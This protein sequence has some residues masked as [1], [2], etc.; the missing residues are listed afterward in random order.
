[1][2]SRSNV[3]LVMNQRDLTG[4]QYNACTF[5]AKGQNII[6]GDIKDVTVSEVNFPY[7]IPNVQAGYD[8][9]TLTNV[10]SGVFTDLLIVV[11]AGFYTG[12]ELATAVNAAIALT[13]SQLKTPVDISNQPVV[14]YDDTSNR[15]IF[16][17]P[18]APLTP[19]WG[20]WNILSPYT[21]PYLQPSQVNDLGKDLLSIMGFQRLSNNVMNSQAN[22]PV[23]ASSGSAPLAFTQ[24]IDI[25]SPQLCKFQYFRDG[26]TTNL[27]RRSDV[28]CRLYICNNIS[29]LQGAPE[30]C[31]PFV[32][33]R[34]FFNARVM[35]WTADNSVGTIDIN[36]YDDVGQPLKTTWQ[37][38]PYQIT[39][40]AMENPKDEGSEIRDVVGMQ[41]Y[42][43]Y[44]NENAAAWANISVAGKN[45]GAPRR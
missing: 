13:S 38:R 20:T 22:P 15:F 29:I 9:F 25:C 17:G 10:Q 39:F 34:Q 27:A 40:N 36:L 23:N 3:H 41:K 43:A 2:K 7:D 21:F 1:M 42:S 14:A 5:N 33:N 30:G 44:H 37:P 12:S 31:R 11:P 26:S 28:I 32:I 6:Q 45:A 19:G 8:T 24:Y 18:A 4:G 16:S 35:R